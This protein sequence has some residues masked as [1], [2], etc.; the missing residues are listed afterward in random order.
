LKTQNPSPQ[1]ELREECSTT[2]LLGVDN[3]LVGV[4]L[5]NHCL[6]LPGSENGNKRS[7]IAFEL[8]FPDGKGAAQL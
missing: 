8:N 2:I 1:E 7:L 5:V 6:A 3:I 4:E